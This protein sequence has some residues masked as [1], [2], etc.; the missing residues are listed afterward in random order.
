MYA[1]LRRSAYADSALPIGGGQTISQPQVVAIMV[2]A[3]AVRPGDRVLDLGCGSGVLAIAAAKGRGEP[4]EHALLGRTLVE[5]ARIERAV[6]VAHPHRAGKV[7]WC[8]PGG[9]RSV[10]LLSQER[11]NVVVIHALRHEGFDLQI[12]GR[13]GGRRLPA[14]SFAERSRQTTP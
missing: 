5:I 7:A 11:R 12:A 10:R 3:L 14:P 2:E 6:A 9:E 1:R 13:C 8:G 4:L